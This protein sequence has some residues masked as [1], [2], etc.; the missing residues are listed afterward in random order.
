[1]VEPTC[2]LWWAR[3]ADV[4]SW[5]V[6][7]LNAADLERRARIEP[8]EARDQFTLGRALIRLVCS[9]SLGVA[10]SDVPVRFDCARCSEQHGP[11]QL[12]AAGG[13]ISLAHG[14]S[15]V[16][17]ALAWGA[18]VGVDVEP[19]GTAVDVDD[20]V[21]WTRTE[22]VLKA[23]HDGLLVD[24]SQLTVSRPEEPPRLVDWPARPSMP[25]R[26]TLHDVP[27][28]A[29]HAACVALIDAPLMSVVSASAGDLVRNRDPG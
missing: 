11:P 5:H 27:P 21:S 24:P 18:Q 1:M 7:L 23:T 9:R 20:A 14:G 13:W 8:D 25:G 26:I 2:E 12:D 19:L 6:A 10:P 15:W 17:V 28:D 29:E 16:V 22:A 4:A 3:L